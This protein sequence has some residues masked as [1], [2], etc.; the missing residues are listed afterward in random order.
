MLYAHIAEERDLVAESFE[1]FLKLEQFISGKNRPDEDNL[2]STYGNERRN[3]R[4]ISCFFVKLKA[5]VYVRIQNRY[6][7]RMFVRKVPPSW[8]TKMLRNA[9]VLYGRCE[10]F[11]DY[12][13]REFALFGFVIVIFNGIFIPNIS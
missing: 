10:K 5:Y 4:I 7:C 11:M 3:E 13:T 12:I 8:R 2:R 1:V 6:K 9:C